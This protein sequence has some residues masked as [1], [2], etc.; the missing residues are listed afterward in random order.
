MRT[1]RKW[2][3]AVERPIQGWV[4]EFYAGRRG[5]LTTADR[6]SQFSFC[7]SGRSGFVSL[8]NYLTTLKLTDRLGKAALRFT[9]FNFRPSK[10]GVYKFAWFILKATRM[11]R[12]RN[13]LHTIARIKVE[14]YNLAE[15]SLRWIQLPPSN[16]M[17]EREIGKS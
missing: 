12:Y 17:L 2:Y 6:D 13:K 8:A 16:I 3:V 10:I 15:P 4:R 11:L 14:Y 9:N 1:P 7:Y 5:T